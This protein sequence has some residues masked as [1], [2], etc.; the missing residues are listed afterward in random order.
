MTPP[1][2]AHRNLPAGPGARTPGAPAVSRWGTPMSGSLAAAV[3]EAAG[4]VVWSG[5]RGDAP[6]GQLQPPYGNAQL[7]GIAHLTPPAQVEDAAED[8]TWG[9]GEQQAAGGAAGGVRAG[10]LSRG[11]TPSARGVAGG[12]QGQ[13]GEEEGQAGPGLFDMPAA[14][15]TST[16]PPAAGAWGWWI[17]WVGGMDANSLEAIGTHGAS[18]L[19][20]LECWVCD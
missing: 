1:H 8:D 9:Y 18:H 15:R 6:S 2:P 4:G 5:G 12:S 3:A 16:P 7:Q 20:A 13:G 19:D 10:H 11:G 14:L 17:G